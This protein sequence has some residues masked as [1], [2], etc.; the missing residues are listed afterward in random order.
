MARDGSGNYTHPAGSNAVSGTTIQST[1]YNAMLDDVEE[2]LND[3][4]IA[5]MTDVTAF[6][7]TILDDA[8]AGTVR[9]TIG[10]S[11]ASTAEMQAGTATGLRA[12]SPDL[13]QAGITRLACPLGM[14]AHVAYSN[15]AELPADWKQADGQAISRTTYARLF[16][17]ISTTYGNGNGSTTFNLPDLR[18]EFIRGWDDGRGIDS[19]RAIGSNQSAANAPHTHTQQGTF[20][21]AN[22]NNGHTHA[23]S[24]T[25]TTGGNSVNHTHTGTFTGS[26]TT[27]GSHQ[28][29]YT[30]YSSLQDNVQL[31]GTADNH[32]E[33][34]QTAATVASTHSHNVSV[35]GTTGNNSVSHTHNVTISGNTGNRS[36]SHKH[37]VT[38]SGATT[39][40]GSEGRPRNV[41]MMAII[42][43]L[44]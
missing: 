25:F 19:G 29:N 32:W 11:T 44:D 35:S 23:Q 9:N 36:S 42:K 7:K 22:E 5:N 43:V 26:T 1:P 27:T 14:V 39:S 31:S 34:T 12:M 16:A 2:A 6:A 4:R 15:S 30:R 37:D 13:V 41:A 24:G 8:D 40:S 38:I 33:N 18:G 3:I 10:L 28:H 20:L 17:L 21:S